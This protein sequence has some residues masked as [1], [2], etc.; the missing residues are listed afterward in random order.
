MKIRVSSEDYRFCI[1]L[2]T[3]LLFSKGL[4]KLGIRIGKRYTKVVP[5]IPPAAVDALCDEIR[6][7]KR[8]HGSWELVH[9]ESPD[10]S[11]VQII[12]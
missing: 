7:I 6:Y 8:K 9:M 5:D 4:L 3:R 1:V 10:G 2:P 11:M 12:L